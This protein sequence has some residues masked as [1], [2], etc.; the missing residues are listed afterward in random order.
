MLE[1][2]K[3]AVRGSAGA[4]AASEDSQGL[5]RAEVAGPGRSAQDVLS[6][7]RHTSVELRY[8]AGFGSYRSDVPFKEI[9][10]AYS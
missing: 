9:G 4:G 8:G 7:L 10:R 5:L 1:C 3:T 6:N 2:M